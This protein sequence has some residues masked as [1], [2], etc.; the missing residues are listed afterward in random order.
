M[1]GASHPAT[2]ATAYGLAQLLQGKGDV[3][4]AETLLKSYGEA[5]EE[6]AVTPEPAKAA[7]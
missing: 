2:R 5:S 4:A 1:L 3:A 6:A 7:A